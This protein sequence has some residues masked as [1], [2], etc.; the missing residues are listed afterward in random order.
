MKLEKLELDIAR[1]LINQGLAKAA[2]SI[3]F[4]AKG[5]KVMTENATRGLMIIKAVNID[6]IIKKELN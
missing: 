1:E 5:A 3:A 6:I 2:D 4:F